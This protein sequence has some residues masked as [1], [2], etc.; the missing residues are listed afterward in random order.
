[1]KPGLIRK[2]SYEGLCPVSVVLTLLTVTYYKL[3]FGYDLVQL[4]SDLVHVVSV[5]EHHY[6]IALTSLLELLFLPILEP[7]RCMR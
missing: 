3:S 6:L 4:L 5:P 7:F 1:M 2:A